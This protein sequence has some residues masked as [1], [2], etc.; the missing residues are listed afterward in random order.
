M[1]TIIL[2]AIKI[3]ADACVENEL[4]IG[5]FQKMFFGTFRSSVGELDMPIYNNLLNA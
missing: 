4:Y 1:F 5:Y 3:E 2:I